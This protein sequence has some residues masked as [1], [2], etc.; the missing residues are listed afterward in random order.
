MPNMEQINICAAHTLH[1]PFAWAACGQCAPA[2]PS[3]QGLPVSLLG[4]VVVSHAVSTQSN[5]AILCT[6]GQSLSLM[7]NVVY[8]TQFGLSCTVCCYFQYC[9]LGLVSFSTL[10]M[11]HN[12]YLCF[13][14]CYQPSREYD[15][16]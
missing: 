14:V 4:Q 12:L 7:C 11:H 13:S 3:R 6:I 15:V 9:I 10:Y 5:R 2:L 1:A 8:D 16:I